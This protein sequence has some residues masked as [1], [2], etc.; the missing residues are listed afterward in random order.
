MKKAAIAA[1]TAI[2]AAVTNRS[3]SKQRHL[4][5]L[6]KRLPALLHEHGK[7]EVHG[8]ARLQPVP[9]QATC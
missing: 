1:S 3:C 8:W 6:R 2:T 7:T 5:F 9:E 4:P